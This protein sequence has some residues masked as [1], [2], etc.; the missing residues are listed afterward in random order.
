LYHNTS[1]LLVNRLNYVSLI[2]QSLA[3]GE[4]DLPIL[5]LLDKRVTGTF[6]CLSMTLLRIII[7][8]RHLRSMRAVFAHSVALFVVVMPWYCL[9]CFIDG[10]IVEQMAR[11]PEGDPMLLVSD[12]VN[13][14]FSVFEMLLTWCVDLLLVSLERPPC[15][16]N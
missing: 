16:S 7:R 8:R 14:T 2:I 1:S 10:R 12:A 11:D 9:K 5:S 6:L 3:F 13:I 15:T 4:H